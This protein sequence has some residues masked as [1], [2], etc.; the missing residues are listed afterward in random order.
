[1]AGITHTDLWSIFIHLWSTS[2]GL[3]DLSSLRHVAF[4]LSEKAYKSSS[5]GFRECPAPTRSSHS[6]TCSWKE[7]ANFSKCQ[8]TRSL[9]R[10]KTKSAGLM[11]THRELSQRNFSDM[12]VKTKKNKLPVCPWLPL[13]TL[14]FT[15][16]QQASVNCPALKTSHLR[17]VPLTEASQSVSTCLPIPEFLFCLNF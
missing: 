4:S 1:M 6:S 14:C 17:S 8:C 11:S 7:L 10:K 16:I 12:A 3:S 13:G 2:L 15:G 5:L 9:L